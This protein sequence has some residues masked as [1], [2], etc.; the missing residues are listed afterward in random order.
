MRV[1]FLARLFAGLKPSLAAG[2]WKPAGMPAIYH[3]LEGLAE[4]PDV[5]EAGIPHAGRRI[6]TDSGVD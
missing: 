5:L 2:E 3:L 6:R 4:D 1:L